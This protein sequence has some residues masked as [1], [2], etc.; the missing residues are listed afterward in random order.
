MQLAPSACILHTDASDDGWN[1]GTSEFVCGIYRFLPCP[2]C[3]RHLNRPPPLSVRKRPDAKDPHRI[4]SAWVFFRLM[5]HQSDTY[6]CRQRDLNP[7]AVTRNRFWVC[8]VCHSDTPAYNADYFITGYIF[9]QVFFS[10]PLPFFH[11]GTIIK[12][13]IKERNRITEK[14]GYSFMA[15][16]Y[17]KWRM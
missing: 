12:Q 1:Q 16:N 17:F 8:I 3:I 14:A 4:T 11:S 10:K 9:W 6:R 2:L 15:V 7:H 13:I 5:C